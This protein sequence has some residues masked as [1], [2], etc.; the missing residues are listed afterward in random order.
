MSSKILLIYPNNKNTT[1]ES[2]DS[3]LEHLGSYFFIDILY[4]S[5]FVPVSCLGLILNLINLYIFFFH[6]KHKNDFKIQLY[7]YIRIYTITSILLNVLELVFVFSQCFRLL[8]RISNTY[9]M[10]LYATFIY[11]PIHSTLTF[12]KFIIDIL[13]IVERLITLNPKKK[14]SKLR[15][16]HPYKICLLVLLIIAPI[17]SPYFLAYIPR[18]ILIFD[19]S[20][21]TLIVRFHFIDRTIF[22]NSLHGQIILHTLFAIRHVLTLSIEISLNIVSYFNLRNYLAKKCALISSRFCKQNQISQ[23]LEENTKYSNKNMTPEKDLSTT[24]I[25][26]NSLSTHEISDLKNRS[27]TCVNEKN[28]SRMVIVL[29]LISIFHQIILITY[30]AYDIRHDDLTDYVL[31]FVANFSS[32]LRHSTTFFI[33]FFY[34]KSFNTHFRIFFKNFFISLYYRCHITGELVL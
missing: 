30:C 4:M 8:E 15:K 31:R 25:I 27:K 20:N 32:A 23:I 13:I 14:L 7:D 19:L 2:F 29:S 17:N 5:L 24:T 16:I 11:S 10:Q 21:N 3:A 9:V 1:C 6:N 22:A 26:G 33:F 28:L 34:N 12:F 18:E